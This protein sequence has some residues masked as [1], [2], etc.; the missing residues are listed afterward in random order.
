M[1]IIQS[2]FE[3]LFSLHVRQ[4]V[5]LCYLEMRKLMDWSN[6][7]VGY[8]FFTQMPRRQA[9]AGDAESRVAVL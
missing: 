4:D 9:D 7:A 5:K 6:G 8:E 1:I 2:V 3:H